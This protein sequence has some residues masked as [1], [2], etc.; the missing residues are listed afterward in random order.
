MVDADSDLT[1]AP[2]EDALEE[3]KVHIEEESGED[4]PDLRYAKNVTCHLAQRGASGE[5]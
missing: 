4:A 1:L 3:G 5:A 2:I